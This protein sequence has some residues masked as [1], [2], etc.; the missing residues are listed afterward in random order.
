MGVIISGLI[1]I[2]SVFINTYYMPSELPL[3]I[4]VG[5]CVYW[6]IFFAIGAYFSDK[7]RN[8]SLWLPFYLL[9][10]G[11]ITQ[12]L[13]YMILEEMEKNGIGIKLSSWIYSLGV[14]MMLISEKVEKIYN[15]NAIISIIHIIGVNSF[16]I[17]LVHMLVLIFIRRITH[18][19]WIEDWVLAIIFSMALIKLAKLI[20]PNISN[21]F[22]GFKQ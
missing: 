1:T 2:I 20:V 16:G 12:I 17:Y 18:I 14:I 21:R 8:Y 6:L 7:N 13:E 9:I 4:S 11:C 5:P 10:V 19:S 3:V 22:L 15:E